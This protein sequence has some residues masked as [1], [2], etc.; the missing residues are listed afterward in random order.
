MTTVIYPDVMMAGYNENRYTALYFVSFM[1]LTFFFFQN[2][3][4][5]SICNIYNNSREVCDSEVDQARTDLCL[6][7]FHLLTGG[8]IDYVSRQQMMGIFLILNDDCD[9]IA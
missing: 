4:L 5:G 3:I 6:R 2:V 9:E 8:D 7:A 1:I